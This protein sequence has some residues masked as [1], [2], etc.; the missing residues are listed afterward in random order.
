MY[1]YVYILASVAAGVGDADGSFQHNEKI[2]TGKETPLLR[3]HLDTKCIILPRQAR[4][5]HRES[6]QKKSAAFSQEAAPGR[7]A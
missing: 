4:D 7:R 5:K 2:P 3:C 1:V 6:T